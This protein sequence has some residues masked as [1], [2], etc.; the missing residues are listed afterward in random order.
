[1]IRELT[2]EDFKSELDSFKN[3][4]FKA[5]NTFDC[6]FEEFYNNF[7]NNIYSVFLIV[8]DNHV[9]AFF[10]LEK[11]NDELIL[12]ALSGEDTSSWKKQLYV[13]ITR[14]ARELKCSS[15]QVYGRKGWLKLLTKYGMTAEYITIN[16]ILF[17]KKVN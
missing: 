8:K 1:M 17:R 10:I 11:E 14:K 15:I 9:K 4:V 3:L 7:N 5:L 13:F 16:R 2:I 12:L 6:S